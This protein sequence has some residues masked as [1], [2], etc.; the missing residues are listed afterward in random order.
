MA[1]WVPDVKAGF[2]AR[3]S[4]AETL[5]ATIK[6]KGIDQAARQYHDLKSTAATG[7]NF[8]EDELNS[9]GYQLIH[10]HQ[11]PEAIRVFQ[12]NIETYPKSSNAYDSLAEGYM[13]AGNKPEA[14]AN[15]QKAIQRNPKNQ[16]SKTML[17]KV[18]EN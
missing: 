4:I 15:Y 7:Y 10:T 3:K 9:L 17:K 13:D 2:D 18:M 5:A 8:D 12:L 16:N 11:L 1:I 14:I 6:T